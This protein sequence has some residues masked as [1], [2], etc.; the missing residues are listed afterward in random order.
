ME[1]S[2]MI[3]RHRVTVAALKFFVLL[4]VFCAFSGQS[5]ADKAPG[6]NEEGIS[7]FEEGDYEASL[8]YFTDALVERPESPLLKYNRGTALA[9]MGK[10]EEALS[11]LQDAASGFEKPEHAAAAHYNSATLLLN[12]N[13]L[14]EAIDEFKSALKLDHDSEDIRHNLELAVRKMQQQQQQQQDQQQEGEQEKEESGENQQEK[15]DQEQQNQEQ[16]QQQDGQSESQP[17]DSREEPSEQTQQASSQQ[18]MESRPMTEEE[19]QRLLDAL[20][21]EEEKS[22]SQ[23]FMEMRSTIRPGDDW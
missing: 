22:Q 6:F 10:T 11:E 19:A 8:E 21:D 23:R 15:Q 4:G 14:P 1:E 12:E 18:P 3:L 9:A 20:N 17:P 5:Y 7:A 2:G 16:D 13:K